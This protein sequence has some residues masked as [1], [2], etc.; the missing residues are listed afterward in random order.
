MLLDE[1][2]EFELNALLFF[3]LLLPDADLFAM[4]KAMTAFFLHGS[5]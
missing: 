2:G 1:N 5:L 4:S 3:L